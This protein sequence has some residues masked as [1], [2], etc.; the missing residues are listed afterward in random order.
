VGVGD[1][2]EHGD[3]PGWDAV[4]AEALY[5]LLEREVIP[6]FYARDGSGI[7]TAWIKRMRESM[8]LLTPRFSADRTVREYTSNGTSGCYHLPRARGKQ[9]RSGPADRRLAAC[10]RAEL[11][12]A[13]LRRGAGRHQRGTPRI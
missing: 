7:P 1:G 13:A 3:D 10:N 6:E 2:Q 4:E 9:R 5:N 8:A 11:G 12:L